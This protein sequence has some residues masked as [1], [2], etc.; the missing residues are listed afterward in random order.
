MIE[1]T[2]PTTL[3]GIKDLAR[4]LKKAEGLQHAKALDQAA[5]RA[6]F[7]NFRHARNQLAGLTP[8]LP[9][10]TASAPEPV[11]PTWVTVAW[12]DID[13]GARGRE[14]CLVALSH[15]MKTLLSATQLAA[16][17]SLGAMFMAADDHLVSGQRA[18]GQVSARWQAAVAARTLQFID[19]T[20]L[21]PTA[22]R[23]RIYP[24]GRF[25]NA[26]PA[27]DHGIGWYDPETR[28]YL[29]TDEPYNGSVPTVVADREAW[30]ERFGWRIAKPD[31]RGMHLPESTELF[32]MA[33]KAF[34]LERVRRALD[35]LP[36]WPETWPGLSRPMGD[37]FETPAEAA[38]AS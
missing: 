23:H 38:A 28:T 34:D 24:E 37:G 11:F 15:P 3:H 33:P 7:Q 20:G 4:D 2:Q 27:T 35:R 30:A 6:G 12:S 18:Q 31:W 8:Q 13:T 22:S 5:V 19:A 26:A 36:A 10:G 21:K 14:T 29:Y 16:S 17:H 32:V 9:R 25:A 1:H